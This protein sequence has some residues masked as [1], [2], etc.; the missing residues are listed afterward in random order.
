M[1]AV[2]VLLLWY[3]VRPKYENGISL[4]A[5]LITGYLAI[6]LFRHMGGTMMLFIRSNASLLYHKQVT[7]IDIFLA[8]VLL[9]TIA[10]LTALIVV[11]MLFI[12]I[13]QIGLPADLPMF[14]LGY[15]Y[16]IWWCM[17]VSLLVASLTER[18]RIVEKIWPVYSYTYMYFGGFFYLADWLPPKLREV[19]LYQPSLQAYEMI[20]AGMFGNAIKTYGDPAYTTLALAFLTV[21]GLWALRDGRKHVVLY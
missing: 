3:A 9:E 1:F 10:N 19:A 20:R 8:R 2:P 5:L 21:V 7:I 12:T 15:F 17:T 14:F 4:I 6:L 11:F 16:M 13:G 18:S